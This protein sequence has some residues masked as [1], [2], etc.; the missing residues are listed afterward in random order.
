MNSPKA[1]ARALWR[2]SA[3]NNLYFALAL[4]LILGV[5]ALGATLASNINL[6]GGQTVEF[7]QGVQ[8]TTACDNS[9]VITPA[10]EFVNATMGEGYYFTSISLSD[11]SS[12]CYGRLFTIRAYKD[13][14]NSPLDIYQT[15]GTDTYSEIKVYD[16][17]GSFSLVDAGLLQ[18]DIVDISG[19]FTVTF[20][21]LGPPPSVAVALATDVDRITIQS[22]NGEAPSGPSTGSLSFSNNLISYGPD[23]TFVLGLDDFTIEAWAN[24]NDHIG[25]IYDTGGNVN[26]EGGFAL[27][28]EDSYLRYRING[29]GSSGFDI[30]YPMAGNWGSWHHFAVTRT[31]GIIRLFLDGHLV[32]SSYDNPAGP[33]VP[34]SSNLINLTKDD[35]DIGG[36]AHF[37]NYRLEGLISSLRVVK[38]SALYINDFTPPT[39]FENMSGALLILRSQ[40]QN[41]MFT[42]YSSHHWTPTDISSPPSWSSDHP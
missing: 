1:L 14:V 10:S 38:G 37:T 36:L 31:A 24:L 30:T 41:S 27:W 7:G 25:S 13:G 3:E 18:D 2:K 12:D 32:A 23:S 21:T 17:A 6:N 11:I 15:N 5:S 33:N 4:A 22:S 35:P 20:T 16:N 9:I 28:L 29:V 42:D 39:R 40:S 26:T 34:T 8:A 19:G